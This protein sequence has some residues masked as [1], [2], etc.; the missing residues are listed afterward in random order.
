ML[1]THPGLPR[2]FPTHSTNM[3]GCMERADTASA[4]DAGVEQRVTL[5]T[6]RGGVRAAVGSWMGTVWVRA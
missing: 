4:M 5:S 3:T 1:R 2:S 6:I